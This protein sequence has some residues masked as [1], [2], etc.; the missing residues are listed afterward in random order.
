MG[1]YVV[2]RVP[3]SGFAPLFAMV[4]AGMV[5]TKFGSHVGGKAVHVREQLNRQKDLATSVVK[6]PPPPP[7]PTPPTHTHTH[8]QTDRHPYKSD[9]V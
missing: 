8:R 7:T 5:M 2:S 9:E 4:S 1:D 3:A 6:S